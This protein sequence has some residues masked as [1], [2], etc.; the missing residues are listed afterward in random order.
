[1]DLHQK[2]YINSKQKNY[3]LGPDTPR[4]R[5]FYLLPKIHTDPEAWTIPH[6]I[7]RGRPIVSDCGSESYRVAEYIDWFLNPISQ[8]HDSYLKDT[9]DFIDKIKTIILEDKDF[10]FTIDTDSLYTNIS[11]ELG[12]RAVEQTFR[13]YPDSNRPDSHIL[14]LLEINLS[15]NDF[16]FNDQ[17]YLQVQGTAMG[18][19]F[20]PAYANI[21]TAGTS[22][23]KKC[24]YKPRVYYRYLDDIF[25]VL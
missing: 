14:Q 11:S 1:M 16:E 24:K 2:H 5:L 21:Y 8:K 12:L 9:Y 25:G 23:L 20:A 6:E 4:A 15:R 3:L 13:K 10:L 19:K 18:K 22:L 17:I 7:P